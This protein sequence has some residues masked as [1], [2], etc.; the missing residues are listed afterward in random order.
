MNL[1]KRELFSNITTSETKKDFLLMEVFSKHFNTQNDGHLDQFQVA[2]FLYVRLPATGPARA[3]L[4]TFKPYGT[5][6]NTIPMISVV[7]H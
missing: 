5:T 4:Y 7:N 6:C 1:C 2:V 3:F